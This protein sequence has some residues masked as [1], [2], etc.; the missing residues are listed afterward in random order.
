MCTNISSIHN[1]LLQRSQAVRTNLVCEWERR[2]EKK[3]RA[4]SFA[5]FN[6]A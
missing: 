3:R 2:E 1:L 6:L 5:C 4:F